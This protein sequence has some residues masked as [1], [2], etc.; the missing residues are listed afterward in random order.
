MINTFE[1]IEWLGIPIRTNTNESIM[2]FF[3]PI[4][5]PL[6]HST[7]AN[8]HKKLASL[9]DGYEAIEK[10]L[11]YTFCDKS[12]MLQAFSHESFTANDICPNYNSLDFVG[13]GIMNYLLCRHLIRDFRRFSAYEIGFFTNL[14]RSNTCF[15]TVSIR[16]EIYK[17]IRYMDTGI[18]NSLGSF[19]TFI[20][21]NQCRPLNDVSQ[22][23]FCLF[24]FFFLVLVLEKLLIIE[25]VKLLYYCYI[26]C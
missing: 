25:C 13:D 12:L 22:A 26:I 1:L 16:H 5:S 10:K 17:Y 23:K 19:V 14:L 18:H 21:K 15:A 20:K 2:E 6:A 11:N 8:K 24:S 3:A 9:L 4:K 7:D